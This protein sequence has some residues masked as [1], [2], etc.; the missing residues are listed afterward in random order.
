MDD[1]EAYYRRQ[2]ADSFCGFAE[3][4]EVIISLAS[5]YII[6]NWS[7]QN[8]NWYRKYFIPSICNHCLWFK[9]SSS[10]VWFVCSDCVVFLFIHKCVTYTC[11]SSWIIDRETNAFYRCSNICDV[12][13][14]FENKNRD[15]LNKCM[16]L[17]VCRI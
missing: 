4:F 9:Y 17:C 13:K 11:I 1:Y 14:S 10:C 12:I 8:N 7:T 16:Y 5:L 6:Y 15:C 3:E 2:R